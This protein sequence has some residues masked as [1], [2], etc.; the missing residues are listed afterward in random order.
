MKSPFFSLPPPPPDPIFGLTAKARAAGPE[1]IDGTI[2]VFLDEDGNTAMFPSTKLA[3]KEISKNLEDQSYA[4]PP[5]S[6]VRGF[7]SAIEKLMFPDTAS[8]TSIAATGGTGALSMNLRLMKLLCS[9]G[10]ILIQTPTWANHQR[11]ILDAG[12]SITE[13]PYFKKG[14]PSIDP[15]IS[16]AKKMKEPFG[17]LLQVG[18]HNPTGLDYSREQLASLAAE[19]YTL[20]CTVLL[21]FA[22][23]GFKAEPEEDAAAIGPFISAGV[24]VLTAWS[25]SKNHSVYGLRTGLASAVLPDASLREKVDGTYAIL[26]RR[27]HSAASI[28]G[29]RVV[30]HV[31]MHHAK[32]WREDL[33]NARTIMQR[34]RELLLK[35]LPASFHPSL[36]GFG[37]FAMLPLNH[38]QVLKLQ[39]KKVFLTFD[40]R[41]NIAG[42][43]ERRI[44]ELCGRITEVLEK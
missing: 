31:Q 40:G 41:I 42:I 15:L 34:K 29:Q 36:A 16:A 8:V 21:D 33:K 5:L 27:I 35:N 4:Y 3:L 10:Q 22:Y 7:F 13:V 1:A 25:A 11:V 6:G 12:L 9:S 30:A 28:F 19:L 43:P 44:G 39:E 38:D 24:P 32:A 37:M 23:Q 18:C 20:P 26:T 17:I 2:G 14:I